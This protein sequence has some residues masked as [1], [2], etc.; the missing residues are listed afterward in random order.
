M[1]VLLAFAFLSGVVTILSPCILPLLPIVLSGGVAG[2]DPAASR[3]LRA[4]GLQD[5]RPEQNRAC[6]IDQGGLRSFPDQLR[7]AVEGPLFH[8]PRPH[9]AQ[10]PGAGSTVR[11]IAR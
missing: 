9:G 3:R 4:G 8:G 7:D 5:R 6:R 11:S 1:A 10:L 2:G